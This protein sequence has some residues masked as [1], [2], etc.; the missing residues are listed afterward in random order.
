MKISARNILK[1]TIV[2]VV[3]GATTS[4]V[5]IDIGGATVTAKT[6]TNIA[7]PVYLKI[8][9]VGDTVQAATSTDIFWTGA[10]RA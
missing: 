2:D 10:S 6:M 4:H 7:L 5:R 3:Q 9:R 1:G 8:Q